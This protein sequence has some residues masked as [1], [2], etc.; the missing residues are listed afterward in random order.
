MENIERIGIVSKDDLNE[1][2]YFASLTEEAYRKGLLYE[3][4]IEKLQMD[5]LALLAYKT[6][7]YTSGESSSVRVEIA[8]SIMAS[9]MY[10]IGIYLKAFPIPD[11]AISALSGENVMQ[12]Y[13][14]GRRKIAAKLRTAKLLYGKV[15]D[16]RLKIENHCYNETVSGSLKQFFKTYNPDFK[17]QDINITA[18]YPLCIS[19]NNLVGVEF[20]A[21]YLQALY[22]ENMF[23]ALF[24][25]DS[26]NN[27]L[28]GY[29]RHYSSLI[30]NIFEQ[31]FT[32]GIGCVLA[33]TDVWDLQLSSIKISQI[34]A[35]LSDKPKDVVQSVVARAYS[36]LIKILGINNPM[37]LE[38]L[39]KC[40][41]GIVFNILN[42]IKLNKLDA[43][44]IQA[45]YFEIF[46]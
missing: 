17:A 19:I 22:C 13:T 41:P 42:G 44:F 31:V 34:Y 29:D 24:C 3:N 10:T 40:M 30:F 6:E 46:Q 21:Q 15:R 11:D 38:Y 25:K 33:N 43:V 9:N 39:Q 1:E 7:R 12:L 45:K 37:L 5:I 28:L 23:C 35:A 18:D 20:I 27:L 14:A 16:S 2:F 32:C 8:E 26:I 4:D 36:Q